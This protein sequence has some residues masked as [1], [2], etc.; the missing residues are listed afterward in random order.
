[1]LGILVQLEIHGR[2]WGT[3]REQLWVLQLRVQH[4]NHNTPGVH[5][6][7]P[8]SPGCST[9]NPGKPLWLLHEHPGHHDTSQCRR[10][11]LGYMAQQGAVLGGTLGTV[12][13]QDCITGI[14]Q[15][16]WHSEVQQREGPWG[17]SHP[18]SAV[19]GP[20]SQHTGAAQGPWGP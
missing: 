10:G 8:N 16:P 3:S 9:G 11:T 4:G 14:T 1:M 15:G 17:L 20:H 13:P 19:L 7:D 12:T 6:G 2:G 18:R 5:C